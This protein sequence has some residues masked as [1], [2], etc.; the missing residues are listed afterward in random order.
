LGGVAMNK[1]EPYFLN[2]NVTIPKNIK[3]MSQQELEK[4]IERL[5]KDATENKTKNQ[6][7]VAMV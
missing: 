1:I 6:K 7:L 2:D 3:E 5:E 4:E